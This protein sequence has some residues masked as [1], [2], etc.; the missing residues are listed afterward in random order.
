M[1]TKTILS[2]LGIVGLILGAILTASFI[3]NN[4]FILPLAYGQAGSLDNSTNFQGVDMVLLSQKMKK[5]IATLI[6][7]VGQ[8]KNIGNDTAQNVEIELTGYDKNGDVM[9]TE[10]TFT[11]ANIVKPN[12]KTSFK[13]L[14]YNENFE[15]MESYQLS[16][17]WQDFNGIEQ[18]VG[19]ASSRIQN[20]LF[21]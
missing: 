5:G 4:F 15:G 8:V 2:I 12:E 14:F 19:N 21:D 17:K 20:T 11:T 1:N 16:L 18:Y 9:G 3:Q 13:M 10:N 6:E 7:V